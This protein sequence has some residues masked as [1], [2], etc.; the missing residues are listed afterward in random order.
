[1]TWMLTAGGR[2]FD[3]GRPRAD[4]IT[5][6]DIA[7]HLALINRFNGATLRPYSVAEHSLFVAE[8]AER[9]LGLRDPFGLMAALLHDAHE[10]Y[11]GDMTYPVQWALNRLL[12]GFNNAWSQMKQAVDDAILRALDVKIDLRDK[13]IKDA[14]WRCLLNE[15]DQVLAPAVH[16]IDWDIDGEPVGPLPNFVIWNLDAEEASDQWLFEVERLLKEVRGG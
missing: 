4:D 16:G 3:L 6:T 10:A 14:D 7:H 9:E 1:M 12:P 5:V 8:I 2:A 15:R 11:L 13:R